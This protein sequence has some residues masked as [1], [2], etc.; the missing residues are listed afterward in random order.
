MVKGVLCN[1]E[2][3]QIIFNNLAKLFVRPVMRLS[4]YLSFDALGKFPLIPAVK[5]VAN[6]LFLVELFKQFLPSLHFFFFEPKN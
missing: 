4:D 5:N 6:R 2:L 3:V 1:G